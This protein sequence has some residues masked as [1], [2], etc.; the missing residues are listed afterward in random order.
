MI[1]GVVTAKEEAFVKENHINGSKEEDE[2]T[3]LR[4]ESI[5]GRKAVEFLVDD[6]DEEAS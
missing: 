3:P 1:V 6:S 5:R 2:V 4:T